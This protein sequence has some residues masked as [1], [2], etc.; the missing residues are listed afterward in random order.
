MMFGKDAMKKYPNLFKPLTVGSK[1]NEV[2]FKNRC[3]VAP[4]TAPVTCDTAGLLTEYGV[5][6]YHQFAKGGFAGFSVP[7]EIPQN[8]GHPRSI[9]IDNEETIPFHDMHK[10]QRLV[11]AYGTVS[12][13]EIYHPGCCMFPKN[14]NIPMSASEMIWNGNY[15]KA[16]TY[17]DMEDVIKLYVDTAIA[18]KR[19]G[20][21]MVNLHYAHG[22][23]MSTFLSPLSNKRTDEFGGSV[24]N[25]CRF[26][27]MVIE[28]IREATGD[29]PIELR[30]NGSDGDDSYGITAED[31]AQQA[32]IF[33]DAG[34]SMVHMCCGNRLDASTRP[35]MF[36]THFLAPAHNAPAARACKKAG[37]KIPVG[38]VGNVHDAEVAE[39]LLAEGTADYIL[40]ARQ[41]IA[42]PEYVNKLRE[43]REDDIRPC[44]H[45]DYCVDGGRRG[46]LAKTVTY[47]AE[48]T[49]DAYCSANPLA[50]QGF[51]KTKI[52]MPT[53]S[54]TV[55]VI[56]GGVAGMQA[57]IT[58]AERGHK[59]VLYEKS[60]KL[61]GVLE[62][63]DHIWFKDR[64]K[65]FR[66]YLIRQVKKNGVYVMLNTEAT[67]ELLEKSDVD[68]VIVAVGGKA[69]MPPIPGIE[70]KNVITAMDALKRQ[71]QLGENIV[72]IGGGLVGCELSI[73]L[74][75]N[76]SKV[77]VVEQGEYLAATGQLC[78]RIHTLKWMDKNNVVSM[79]ETNCTEITDKGVYVQTGADKKFIEADT[80]VICTGIVPEKEERDKF[81]GCAFE[82]VNIGD[83]KKAANIREAV[84]A[85]YDAGATVL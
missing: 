16:M 20:F 32:L 30:L 49:F 58:A 11:H 60:D 79:L 73:Q 55:A 8:G 85:G 27:R 76:G 4:M 62:F 74:G 59:V 40:Y 38:V 39:Q 15:V 23:L 29:M 18:A 70:N 80:V 63:A 37:V 28:A 19:G 66:E 12:A 43:G 35:E 57:A 6:F 26:P 78:E 31:A 10:L 17:K 13:V 9:V 61:G 5:D 47:Q 52:P 54:K 41:A 51:W 24:E 82:V 2:T 77:T 1:G 50:F 22:W 44:L 83:C 84:A 53:R 72:I 46:A 14:G 34:V 45:C 3:I 69:A 33:E 65:M 56:G 71:D 7:I 75:G 48:S 81:A 36:P 64:I 68:H 25:R 42:D 67:P 21:D